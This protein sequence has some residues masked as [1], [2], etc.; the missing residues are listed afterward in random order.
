MADADLLAGATQELL[1][2]RPAPPSR[3]PRSVL[4]LAGSLIGANAVSLG[5]RFVSG[6][7]QLFLVKDPEVLGT[8]K[9]F[10]IALG[11][12]PFFQGGVFHGLNRELPYYVGKGD[13]RRVEE[14]AAAAQAWALAL[15]AIAALVFFALAGWNLLRGQLWPATGWA[16]CAACSFTLF[17]NTSYLQATFRTGH[18]FARL[19]LVNVVQ[20]TLTVAL[21]V[22]V[23]LWSF[24]G[25]CLR[26]M[27]AD[28]VAMGL[29]YYWRP[30]RVGPKLDLGCLKHLLVIGRRSSSRRSSTAI[31]RPHWTVN[32]SRAS[33]EGRGW[34]DY[35]PATQV[36]QSFE[37]LPLAIMQ[38]IYPRMAEQFGRTGSLKD[39]IP[40]TVKPD[41]ARLAAMM[42]PLAVAGWW[43]LPPIVT[44]SRTITSPAR[45]PRNGPCCRPW[46]S[47]SPPSTKSSWWPSGKGCTRWPSCWAWAH[48]PA[49][50]GGS[51]TTAAAWRPSRKPC[52]WGESSSFWPVTP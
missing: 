1:V 8:F 31:G 41:A 6:W 48:I 10:G 52:S 45:G 27:I 23:Y 46:C 24:Y 9:L 13:R 3:Q 28:L 34:G 5:L 7:L 18:D 37:F 49:P 36:C 14:L 35:Y 21:L 50:C 20:S 40:M 47:P 25:L 38:V 26:L 33:L 42:I 11:Y 22:L 19:A 44:R 30:V 16:T 32:S 51:S 4:F 17:Y 39:L 15:S 29:L 43:L 12:V 2:E